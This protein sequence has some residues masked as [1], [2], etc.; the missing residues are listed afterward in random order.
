MLKELQRTAATFRRELRVYREALRH[1]DTPVLARVLLGL[2]VGYALLPFD[3]IP[4]A[5]PVLGW[6]DDLVV[7][8]LLVR[9][10]LRRIPA[11]VLEVCRHRV[12]GSRE[13]VDS[14]ELSSDHGSS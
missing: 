7:V 6:L 4:D 5:I 10:G 1:P 14:S 9:A 2:A 13:E 8:P 12:E 11:D 3:L